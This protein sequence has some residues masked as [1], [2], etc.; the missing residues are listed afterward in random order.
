[1]QVIV[2][3]H[4]VTLVKNEIVNEG[5]YNVQSCNFQFSSDYDGLP[6]IAIFKTGTVTKQI[7]LSG[8][9][10]ITPE[11]VLQ[12]T[13]IVGLGVY[14][15]Q[16]DGD[17]LVL[18]YSPT[19]AV[20]TVEPGSYDEG[21]APTPPT[22]SVIEQLQEEI[23]Q[24]ANNITSL[25]NVTSTHT[26]QVGT[27]QSDVNNIKTEQITQNGNIQA[28]TNDISNIKAEQITQNN[29]IAQNTHDIND[30]NN[31]LVNYSL[32]TETGS[33]I[34]LNVNS[35]NYQMTAILKD[36]NGNVIYT[37]NVIDLPIESM[38]VNV[39]Y[40]STTKEIVFTLQNGTTLRVSVA[41]LVSGLVSTDEL[42]TILANYYTKTEIDTLLSSKANSSDVYTKSE[43][44]TLLNA[45]VDTT[46]YTQ[47]QA[48]QDTNIQNNAN[49]IEDIESL[50][51]QMPTVSGQGT[52][53]SLENVLNYRLMKFL[54]QGVSSQEST[55]GKN[56]CNGTSKHYFANSSGT[57]TN[58]GTNAYLSVPD[59]I[60]VE[61]NTQYTITFY[62][63]E[64]YTSGVYLAEYDSTDTFIQRASSN[65]T[66]TTGATTHYVFVYIYNNSNPFTTIDTNIQLEQGS[67]AT[68]YE[69]YTG[70]Q[71]APSPSYPYPVKSVTGDNSLVITNSDNT[72]TQTYPLSL[73][74]IELN[75]SPDGT[76]RD[77]IYGTFDNWYKREYIGKTTDA[78][79]STSITINDMV[80]N[81]GFY[82]YYG[83][84]LNDKTITYVSAIPGTNTILYQKT[85]YTD[86]PITDTTLIDQLNNIY[87]NAHSYND[88][89]NITTT[90]ES[91][92]EQMY[93]DIEALAKGEA[94]GTEIDPTVP[95]HVKEITQQNI[96]D[97]NDKQ[98]ELVS[99][100]N[101]KTINNESILGSGNIEIQGGSSYT[102]GTN[103]EITNENVINNI[104]P[105]TSLEG[106]TQT[107]L[108]KST[109]LNSNYNVALGNSAIVY[110]GG[111]AVGYSS[112]A[113]K[114]GTSL[115]CF[116]IASETGTAIGRSANNNL[117]KGSIAIGVDAQN[118]KQ[119]Q[120]MIGGTGARI[121]ELAIYTSSGAKIMATQEYVDTAIANAI[122]NTLG[123]SY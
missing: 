11:E 66:F 42:N 31:S 27:L 101:I 24:N 18:R 48:T 61:P 2:D 17:N 59:K 36:K 23:T 90:Y 84:T 6:K 121:N 107:G 15:Y 85:Q 5:E 123:G 120:A 81:S 118:T 115:G 35:S 3:K 93:L 14:A 28:N 100:T 97:W 40:D 86:I 88:V 71:P 7:M 46:T 79:G 26:T 73:G 37:S 60:K 77:G 16:T 99:G 113:Q 72:E 51:N 114:N 34:A 44:N 62:G 70:G 19:P 22:P 116:A 45:K 64:S 58:A 55:T 53:L 8:N 69:P 111:S 89:T 102:A 122:T 117:K 67:T 29:N 25:E 38:I 110:E 106:S 78:S 80:S 76:I 43:A 4:T 91:G 103:I 49:S 65:L 41:D 105:Y 94:S 10:C 54:P 95:S 98:D 33:Q 74:N 9:T 56:L 83:G 57:I 87:N 109:T 92:N 47:G 30:I 52:D 20:F 119:N 39:T 68:S 104:I 112:Y 63:Y 108:G 1:M 13:G 75:S 50:I 82:S 96:T 12:T 21:D 32:I